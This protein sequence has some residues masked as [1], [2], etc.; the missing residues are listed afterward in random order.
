MHTLGADRRLQQC[1]MLVE[2]YGYEI[3]FDAAEQPTWTG[4]KRLQKSSATPI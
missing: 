1:R 2:Y 4:L 3:H